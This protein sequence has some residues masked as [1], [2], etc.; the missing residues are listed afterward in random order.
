MICF[1]EAK[2]QQRQSKIERKRN[3]RIR[4][5]GRERERGLRIKK[6]REKRKGETNKQWSTLGSTILRKDRKRSFYL[7]LFKNITQT[8]SSYCTVS[9]SL[10]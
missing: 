6:L 9:P 3:K 2:N 5:T 4:K 7:S 8:D 1:V 10:T